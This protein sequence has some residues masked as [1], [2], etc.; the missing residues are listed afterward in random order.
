MGARS[1]AFLAEVL[2]LHT[3][4]TIGWASPKPDAELVIKAL[5]MAYAQRRRPRQVLFH[6]DLDN[7]PMERLFRSLKSVCIPAAGLPDGT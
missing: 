5:D 1:L 7:S 4:R 2:D 3:R 6:S